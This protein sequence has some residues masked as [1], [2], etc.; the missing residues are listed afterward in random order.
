MGSFIAGT[1]SYAPQ[2]VV[3]NADIEKPNDGIDLHQIVIGAHF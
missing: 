2:K 1:G 3:T